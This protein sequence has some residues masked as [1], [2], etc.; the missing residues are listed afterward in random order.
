MLPCVHSLSICFPYRPIHLAEFVNIDWSLHRAKYPLMWKHGAS[1]QSPTTYLLTFQDL[2]GYSHFVVHYPM[3]VVSQDQG[4]GDSCSFPVLEPNSVIFTQAISRFRIMK[5]IHRQKNTR[6]LCDILIF[7]A[8]IGVYQDLA[9]H[10]HSCLWATI[11]CFPGGGNSRIYVA[12]D[13]AS[14]CKKPNYQKTDK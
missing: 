5:Y 9:A 7:L 12:W 3:T 8:S 10:T 2:L 4:H 13:K 6:Q 11:M 14:E 1:V